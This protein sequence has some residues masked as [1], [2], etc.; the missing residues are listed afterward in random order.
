MNFKKILFS[1]ALPQQHKLFLVLRQMAGIVGS[2]RREKLWIRFIEKIIQLS[3]F[4]K[5]KAPF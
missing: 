3:F 2:L 4:L 1:P 5:I